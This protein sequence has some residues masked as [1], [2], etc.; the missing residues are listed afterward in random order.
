LNLIQIEEFPII[1]K[2][3]SPIFA[4]AIKFGLKKKG[5]FLL[6][7]VARVIRNSG[8]LKELHKNRH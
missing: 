4:N 8:I 6:F 3:I 5:I 2:E 1:K 7:F